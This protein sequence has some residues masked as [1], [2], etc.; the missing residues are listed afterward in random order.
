[1]IVGGSIP[2]NAL[3]SAPAIPAG[4]TGTTP[5]AG[6][7]TTKLATTAFVQAALPTP[8]TSNPAMDGAASAGSSANYARGDHVHPADTSRA[9]LASPAFTGTPTAPTATVGTNTTQLAT[10]AFVLA[11]ASSVSPYTSN[12]AANGTAS[13]GSSANYARGDHVHPTDTSRAALASPAFTGTPTSVTPSTSDNSTN[14]ATTAYVQNNL[15]S[16]ASFYTGSTA[17]NTTYP[18]GSILYVFHNATGTVAPNASKT[19]YVGTLSSGVTGF[20]DANS[21]A[22]CATGTALTG[23]WRCRQGVSSGGNTIFQR[24]A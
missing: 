5:T 8:Y 2:G 24:T 15:A 16:V 14:V 3:A 20:A 7:N 9:A 6:D 23:T 1:M 21:F 17:A 4:A 12:P 19:L 10:C 11:N 13:P 18:I 22:C